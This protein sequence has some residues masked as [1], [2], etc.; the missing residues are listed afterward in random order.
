MGYKDLCR[1]SADWDA[2]GLL[3]NI[4]G[5]MIENWILQIIIGSIGII[6]GVFIMVILEDYFS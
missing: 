3:S 4:G 6:L 2:Y 1:V 5:I